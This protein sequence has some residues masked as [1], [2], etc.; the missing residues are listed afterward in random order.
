MQADSG[1]PERSSGVHGG[2]RPLA[3]SV[4]PSGAPTS[5]APGARS[6]AASGC[7]P[8]AERCHGTHLGTV[9]LGGGGPLPTVARWHSRGVRRRKRRWLWDFRRR[10]SVPR[11]RQLAQPVSRPPRRISVAAGGSICGFPQMRSRWSPLGTAFLPPTGTARYTRLPSVIAHG[12][13]DGGAVMGFL[14]LRRKAA[15]SGKVAKWQ[16]RVIAASPCLPRDSAVPLWGAGGPPLYVAKWQCGK[17]A[18]R[19]PPA[20]RGVPGPRSPARSASVPEGGM[21]PRPS[22]V[23]VKRKQARRAGAGCFPS[24]ARRACYRSCSRRTD[25]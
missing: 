7:R 10:G 16:T 18:S 5:G 8:P 13:P 12:L 9:A 23:Q 20:R 11:L 6:G 1:L 15:K 3:L 24:P 17:V 25:H 2:P 22:S 4:D 14:L 19:G 21:P